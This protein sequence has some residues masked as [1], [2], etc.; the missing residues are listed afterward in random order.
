MT[1][2]LSLSV[3]KSEA[4]G[5]KRLTS[6]VQRFPT[7]D[8]TSRRQAH[9]ITAVTK[10]EGISVQADA[11]ALFAKL[12]FNANTETN[13]WKESFCLLLKGFHNTS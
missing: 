6:A 12:L 9:S 5:R 8:T 13:N 7:P 3:G 11:N 4:R 10:R 2:S 1:V